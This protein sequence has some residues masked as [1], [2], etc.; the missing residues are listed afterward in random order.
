[1]PDS[2]EERAW[3]LFDEPDNFRPK[4]PPPTEVEHTLCNGHVV[5]LRLVGS[6]PLWGHH[7]WNAAGTLS[8]YLL[9]HKATCVDAQAV[10]ELGAAAGLPSITAARAGARYVVATDYPDPG[11]VDNLR[12]NLAVNGCARGTGATGERANAL[13]TGYIWGAPPQALLADVAAYDTILMSDLIFNHQAHVALLDTTDA[14]LAAHGQVLVFFSHH[15]PHLA[16]KDMAFFELAAAR[17]YV[18]EEV[19]QWR[20]A[21]MFPDDPGDEQVRATVHGWRMRRSTCRDA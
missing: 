16:A 15:R 9:Q 3:A 14:C 11:L 4:T 19:G 21:P 13:A 7:L 20:L 10:L 8:D 5:Y 2:D 17:G 1:M 6:H 18:C 12:H